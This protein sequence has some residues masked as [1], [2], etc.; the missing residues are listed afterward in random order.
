M[1]G[2]GNGGMFAGRQ[3]KVCVGRVDSV[4]VDVNVWVGVV[5]CVDTCGGVWGGSAGN[6]Q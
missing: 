3:K 4:R 6:R 1:A 5:E 2:N